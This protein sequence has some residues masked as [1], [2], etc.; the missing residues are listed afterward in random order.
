MLC[1]SPWSRFE[2]TTSVVIINI[3]S[4]KSNYHISH[5]FKSIS[6]KLLQVANLFLNFNCLCKINMNMGVWGM[7]FNATYNM[8]VWGMVFNTTYNM[9]VWGLVFHTTYN[10]GVW[11]LVF[12]TTYNMGVWGMVFN[13]T[14]NMGVWGLVFSTTYNMGVGGWWLMPLS[15]WVC[16]VWCLAPLT[17]WVCEV[18]CLTPLTI[19]VCEVWCLTPLT[20]W[21]CEVWCLTPLIIW[22]CEVWCLTPLTIIFQLY[23]GS[24]FYWWRKP[25]YPEKTSDMSQVTDKLYHIMLY[26]VHLVWAGFEVKTSVV[27]GT[28]CIGSCKSNYHTTTMAPNLCM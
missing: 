13:T 7:V 6:S 28:D 4:C 23:L 20:I 10:M 15:I 24:Q 16:E 25:E 14:Y 2:L 8:G 9:G 22:V 1:T 11:G 18:W 21:V 19:W 5:W 26:W 3:C 27:T 17:I 12:N